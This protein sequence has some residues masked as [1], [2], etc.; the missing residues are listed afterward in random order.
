MKE[1][2]TEV[3]NTKLPL[4]VVVAD[5]DTRVYCASVAVLPGVP[6]EIEVLSSDPLAL[7]PGEGFEPGL[8]ESG[9]FEHRS[10]PKVKAHSRSAAFLQGIETWNLR[11][12]VE[13]WI[14]RVSPDLR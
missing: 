2:P 3:W 4:E 12:E 10:S 9:V 13:N 11:S 8:S 1:L 5:F 14:P 7:N 6:P